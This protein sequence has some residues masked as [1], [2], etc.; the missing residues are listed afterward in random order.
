MPLVSHLTF[1]AVLFLGSDKQFAFFERVGKRFFNI[2]MDP[3]RHGQHC[4]RE[5]GVV[6]NTDRA[7]V[8][9]VPD[10][11]EHLS[12]VI[13]D[14]C[15]FAFV[16]HFVFESLCSRGN[17]ITKCDAMCQAVVNRLRADGTA[18]VGTTDYSK[19]QFFVGGT[20]STGKAWDYC[21]RCRCGNGVLEGVTTI[22]SIHFFLSVNLE[23]VANLIHGYGTSEDGVRFVSTVL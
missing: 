11:F 14:N 12:K 16:L 10:F 15:V 8:Y 21:N 7:G 1:D 5:M 4:D 13:E 18:L 19:I 3:H 17:H 9:L 23:R 2:N 6:R 22:Q 20:C